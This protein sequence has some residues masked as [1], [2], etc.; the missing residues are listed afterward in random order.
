VKTIAE[1]VAKA[2]SENPDLYRQ[3]REATDSEMAAQ[4]A[5]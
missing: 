3:Y 1:G 4:Q 2:A 5:T